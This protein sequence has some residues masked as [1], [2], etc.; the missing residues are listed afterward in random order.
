MMI[1]LSDKNILRGKE[2]SEEDL[3]KESKEFLKS[4]MKG[5]FLTTYFNPFALK[6]VEEKIPLINYLDRKGYI[7]RVGDSVA[8]FHYNVTSEGKH[9][10]LS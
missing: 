5:G 1:N 9:W 2:L 8:E 6:D 10:A 4:N 3:E 7:V